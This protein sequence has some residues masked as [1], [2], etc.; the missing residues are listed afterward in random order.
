MA[1]VGRREKKIEDKVEVLSIGVLPEQKVQLKILAKN[2]KK[3]LSKL[4][5]DYIDNIL[6]VNSVEDAS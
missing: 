1:K 4:L 6:L 2:Q 3:S 5:R